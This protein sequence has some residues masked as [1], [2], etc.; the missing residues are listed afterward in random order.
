MSKF[1]YKVLDNYI[2][3]TPSKPINLI[4]S[5]LSES[6][7]SEKRL[8]EFS[9]D[10]YFQEAIFLASPLLHTTLLDWLKGNLKKEK[11]EKLKISLLK[12]ISR[13]SSRCTPFGLFAG[14]CLGELQNNNSM[15]ILNEEKLYKRYTRLDMQYLITYSHHLSYNKKLRNSFTFYPNTS[16][17][18]IGSQYRYIEYSYIG[19]LQRVHHIEAVETDPHLEHTLSI[20]SKGATLNKLANELTQ[21]DSEITLQE[22]K[23]Y[24]HQ[25]IDN[26]LLFSNIEASC[27][28]KDYFATIKNFFATENKKSYVSALEEISGRLKEIDKSILNDIDSYHNVKSKIDELGI[29]TD[30]KFLFQTDLN[31][32]VSKNILDKKIIKDIQEGLYF[33]NKLSIASNKT[34]SFVL[35]SFIKKFKERYEDQEVPLQIALDNEIGI[36]YSINNNTIPGNHFL[37]KINLTQAKKNKN[38]NVV[39]DETNSLLHHKIIDA[40]EKK[41]KV[42]QLNLADLPDSIPEIWNDL[43]DTFSLMTEIITNNNTQKVMIHGFG[44]SSGANLFGRFCISDI[45]LREHTQNIIN[46]EQ[47]INQN[48]V[49][50]EISHIPQTRTGNIIYRP[51]FTAYEIPYLSRSDKPLE[52]QI[53]VKDLMVSVRN[54]KILLRSKKLN[55]LIIPRLANAHSFANDSLPVYH[56]LCDLQNQGKREGLNFNLGAM[57]NKY[58]FIPRIEYKNIILKPSTWNFSRKDLL[59]YTEKFSSDNELLALM[60]KTRKQ[61]KIPTYILLVEY[62]NQL[63]INLENVT[64]IKMMM[65]TIGRKEKFTFKEFLYTNEEQIVKRHNNYFTNQFIF[66]FYNSLKLSSSND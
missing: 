63:L 29:K 18:K 52:F 51:S 8:K 38:N 62:D 31:I 22:A 35:D 48:S 64:S 45:Q 15:I 39:W 23:K 9:N 50:A 25:L 4:K 44:G 3:R 56:F 34:S 66:T 49:I 26:Q 2:L 17:Y 20:A 12:Y 57:E 10:K 11:E 6:D 58:T 61:W 27:I 16:L 36:G 28:G 5:L 55:K 21:F 65:D 33:L 13:M 19:G 32:T 53:E 47:K 14:Y 46:I 37:E 41:L 42:I 30:P 43:P 60:G 1:P 54:N 7:I 24:I 59:V 40:H